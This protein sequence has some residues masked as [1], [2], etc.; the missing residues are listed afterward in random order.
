VTCSDPFVVQNDIKLIRATYFSKF[1]CDYSSKTNELWMS[2]ATRFLHDMRF[3]FKFLTF[4]S[5]EFTIKLPQKKSQSSGKKQTPAYPD[6]SYNLIFSNS[7]DHIIVCKTYDKCNVIEKFWTLL[8]ITL[9]ESKKC[10]T[11][12]GKVCSRNSIPS[13]LRFP[14]RT[15]LLGFA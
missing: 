2:Q 12:L 1:H 6:K 7:P 11:F 15:V 5:Q 8:Y 13:W 4:K 3:Y 10:Q 14:E 9:L